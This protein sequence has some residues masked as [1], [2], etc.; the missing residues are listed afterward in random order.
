MTSNDTA[1]LDAPYTFHIATVTKDMVERLN[2]EQKADLNRRLRLEIAKKLHEAN[3]EIERNKL[4]PE[5]VQF[6]N[7]VAGHEPE[8]IGKKRDAWNAIWNKAFHSQMNILAK[9][10]IK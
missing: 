10:K 5:A 8:E 2:N 7:Q 4:I 6:A 3:Y 1:K 9:E